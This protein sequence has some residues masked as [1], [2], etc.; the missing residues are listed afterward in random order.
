MRQV[1]FFHI[2]IWQLKLN[3][4]PANDGPS[5]AMCGTAQPRPAAAT[6]AQSTDAGLQ[7]REQERHQ[8]LGRLEGK[9]EQKC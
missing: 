1:G 9:E 2:F 3:S 4:V 7:H 5:K 6:A 8:K